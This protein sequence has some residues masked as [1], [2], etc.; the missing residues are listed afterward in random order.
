MIIYIIVE[1]FEVVCCSFVPSVYF[2]IR[3]DRSQHFTPNLAL[4]S[5]INYCF[6]FKFSPKLTL[7]R[8][9]NNMQ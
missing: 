7:A 6:I 1:Y 4:N 9:V 2:L 8:E 3:V 5:S